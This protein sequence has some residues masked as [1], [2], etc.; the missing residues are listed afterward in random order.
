MN[1]FR[2]LSLLF[3]MMIF[4]SGLSAQERANF[5]YIS[6]LPGSK[7]INPEN[8]IALSN[9]EV[10]DPS[11]VSE[12]MI[13][14]IGSKSGNV[15]GTV[16]LS[17]DGK[18]IFFRPDTPFFLKENVHVD[19][20]K[21]IK[22]ER[23]LELEEL[24]FGFEI[25]PAENYPM[26]IEYYKSKESD[27]NHLYQNQ[28]TKV[29]QKVNYLNN[30]NGDLPPDFIQP[31][32]IQYGDP[33]PGYIFSTAVPY[34]PGIGFHTYISI[35]DNYGIPV[36]FKK[37]HPYVGIDLKLLP[38]GMLAYGHWS[39]GNPVE[40][41]YVLMDSDFNPVDSIFMG[42]GYHLDIHDLLLMDNG[43]YLT[44]A[45]DP[46][47]VDMSQVVPGGDTNA[48]VTGLII[49]E[50]DLDQNVYF[51]WRSWDHFEITDATDDIDLTSETID[52]AHGNAF[53]FDQNGNIVVSNRN[54]DEITKIKYPEGNLIW[55]WGL[56]AKN[57]MF[58]FIN[59]TVGFS[60]QHD[61]R[62]HGDGMYSVYDNGNLHS[63]PHSRPLMYSLDEVNMTATLEWTID[64][65]SSI[66]AP[67]TGSYRPISNGHNLISWGGIVATTVGITELD[68]KD[69]VA[70]EFYYP[71][72]IYGY[73]A[74]RYQWQNT[75]L[76]ASK[77][78]IDWGEYSGYTPI[79]R[80]VKV[81]N[82]S[83]GEMT[84]TGLHTHLGDFTPSTNLPFTIEANGEANITVNFFPLSSGEFKD[85]L[86]VIS[87]NADT[88]MRIATQVH[89]KGSYGA[90]VGENGKNGL[91]IAYPNPTSGKFFIEVREY[92]LVKV[93]IINPVGEIVT[94][95]ETP[96]V[97][98]VEI[99]LSNLPSGFYFA[100]LLTQQ[101]KISNLR[102]V[103]E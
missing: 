4:L 45:Y 57:N 91:A 27:F 68:E 90:S 31:E 10:L 50:V 56:G 85:V 49:Q 30:R 18:T 15:E 38:D 55:R 88:S 52:Y 3:L 40:N 47:P 17:G 35:H 67:F 34:M 59:D 64:H 103:K 99:D 80:I 6:P 39:L 69:E 100:R 77:D 33:E 11:S 66:F 9:G 97:K 13:S 28:G 81:Y 74:V 44:M 63:P 24:S 23:G 93:E 89:L 79:P 12:T 14:V 20:E 65:D 7:Y 84:I 98:K 101:G 60:H 71:G 76:T 86:T 58:T 72:G 26:L 41:C 21:G 36:F 53:D 8:N 96:S 29:P 5:T 43:H 22:T 78:T 48:V 46:Q 70:L 25:K 75:A 82:N 42:N 94:V 87:E 1:H 95:I 73:R 2:K 51:Q 32:V 92:D 37:T 16:R 61:I 102:L 83:D 54:M 62:Y 19:I